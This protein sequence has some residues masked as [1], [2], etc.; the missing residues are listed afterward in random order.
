MKQ[1]IINLLLLSIISY[2]LFYCDIKFPNSDLSFKLFIQKDNQEFL[3]TK[4]LDK[5]KFDVE[6]SF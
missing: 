4:N 3:T 5:L 2:R 1:S 6:W